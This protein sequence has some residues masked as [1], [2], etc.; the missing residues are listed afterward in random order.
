MLETC[1]VM[2]VFLLEPQVDD[3]AV[4]NDDLVFVFAQCLIDLD[5][6][7]QIYHSLSLQKRTAP[8]NAG[9]VACKRSVFVLQLSPSWRI[10]EHTTE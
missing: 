10:G 5:R 4:F 3:R 7:C 8:T 2:V 9:A 1:Q 6:F